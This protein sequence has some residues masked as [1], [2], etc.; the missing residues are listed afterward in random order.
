MEMAASVRKWVS[1][2]KLTT[3]GTLWGSTLAASFAYNCARP[4]MKTSLRLIHAR[5]HAQG[6]TLAALSAA[7][8]LHLYEQNVEEKKLK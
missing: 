5:I 4:S 1:D 7:A 2:N 6:I 3:V 8:L